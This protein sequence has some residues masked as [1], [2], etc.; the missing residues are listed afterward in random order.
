MT[1]WRARQR[2]MAG[3]LGWAGLGR[4]WLGGERCGVR[5]RGEEGC[6]PLSGGVGKGSRA[7]TF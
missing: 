7:Q 4:A 6:L 1:L 2:R 3:G 5:L